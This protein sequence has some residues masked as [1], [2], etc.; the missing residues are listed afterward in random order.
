MT[1]MH[2][3]ERRRKILEMLKDNPFVSVS[4]AQDTLNSSPATI[5]RDFTDLAQ[6][7]LVVRGQGGIHRIDDAPIMGVLPFSRRRIDHPEGKSRIAAAAAELLEDGQIVIIDGGTTTMKLARCISPHVRV[8]TNSLPLAQ[9]LNEPVNGKNV[10]PEVNMTGG[11]VYP[12]SEVLLGPQTVKS[13][14]EYNGNWAFISANGIMPDGVFNSNNLV[15]DTQRM[16][17][18]RAQRLAVLVDS[19]KM[20]RPAMV[21]VCDLQDIDC[22]ITDANPP[23]ELLEALT[24]KGVKIIVV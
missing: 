13:L 21:K 9:A 2:A 12:R 7:G 1:T 17:I 10:V 14:Q 8:I 19:S 18:Q 22:L 16:M 4:F 23:G 5:R 6:Q 15:V 24:E 20:L 11:Y 3:L